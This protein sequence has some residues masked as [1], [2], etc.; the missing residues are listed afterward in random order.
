MQKF[1]I[2][3]IY[4]LG[5]I[6]PSEGVLQEDSGQLSA[7]STSTVFRFVL[8]HCLSVA[9]FDWLHPPPHSHLLPRL[10]WQL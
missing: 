9:V 10:S 7:A 8:G 6:F 2:C 5:F 4:A 3:A 1:C